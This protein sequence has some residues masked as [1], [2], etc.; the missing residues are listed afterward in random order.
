MTAI[1]MRPTLSIGVGVDKDVYTAR[2]YARNA[3]ELAPGRGGDQAVIKN[4]EKQIFY[5]RQQR[6]NRK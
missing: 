3:V 1:N 2:E 5:R 6:R 4:K